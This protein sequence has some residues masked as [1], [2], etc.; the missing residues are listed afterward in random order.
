MGPAWVSFWKRKDLWCVGLASAA[1]WTSPNPIG[2]IWM[3]LAVWGPTCTQRYPAVHYP[4][5][6][7]CVHYLPTPENLRNTAVGCCYFTRYLPK[8]SSYLSAILLPSQQ[9]V[10]TDLGS[11]CPGTDYR[12]PYQSEDTLQCTNLA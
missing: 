12:T 10:T 11:T 5:V 8:Y 4:I 9:A 1:V 3:G 2:H 6:P 7:I